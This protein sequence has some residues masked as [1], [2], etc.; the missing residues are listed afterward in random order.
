MMRPK[1]KVTGCAR[2]FVFFIIFL[3]IVYFGAAYIRGEDGMQKLKDY[4]H[5]VIGRQASPGSDTKPAK[6]TPSAGNPSA[7]T[8]A[9]QKRLDEAEKRIRELEEELKIRDAVIRELKK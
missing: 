9:L 1:Y 3:P 6:P 2:F 5:Q 7:E 8:E 4:Y